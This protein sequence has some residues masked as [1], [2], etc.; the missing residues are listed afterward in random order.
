MRIPSVHEYHTSKAD[1]KNK[2]DYDTIQVDLKPSE[3]VDDLGQFEN[4]KEL[5]RFVVRLKYY[6]RKSLEYTTLMSFLKKKRG[7]YCCGIH[8][9]ITI[10]DKFPIE[11]HHTPLVMEDIL[12]IV[13]NKRIKLNESLKMSAIAKEVMELHYD[14]LVGLYPLCSTCH[15][16]CHAEGS[17]VFIPLDRVFGDPEQFFYIYNEYISSTMKM[18]FKSILELNKG[19]ALIRDEVPE[20]LVR[21]YILVEHGDGSMYSTKGLKTMINQISTGELEF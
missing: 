21:K 7:M 3:Y 2:Y 9:N 16:M 15:E 12:Y 13:I 11:I 14:G 20:S 17:D 5:H 4:E 6:V 8:N 10:W 18:K 19:Y 1:K